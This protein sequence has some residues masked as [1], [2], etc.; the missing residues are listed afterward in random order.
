M[1]SNVIPFFCLEIAFFLGAQIDIW[2]VRLTKVQKQFLY[3]CLVLLMMIFAGG[4]WSSY[5]VGYD[6][7]IFDYDTYHEIFDYSEDLSLSF[8]EV[9]KLNTGGGRI[10]IFDL[11]LINTYF[12]REL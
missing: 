2:P 4:R 3:L 1:I 12:Y 10:W 7:W 6:A 5:V 8:K 9:I 11:E